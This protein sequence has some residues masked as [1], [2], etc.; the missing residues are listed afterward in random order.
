MRHERR[1][2]TGTGTGI[3][4]GTAKWDFIG[5]KKTRSIIT[6]RYD[7]TNTSKHM[8]AAGEEMSDPDGETILD[9][10]IDSLP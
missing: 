9:T 1:G 5:D 2:L 7:T 10:W 6:F 4:D 8:P 3:T